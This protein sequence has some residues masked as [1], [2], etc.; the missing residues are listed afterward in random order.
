MAGYDGIT[1]AERRFLSDVRLR[2]ISDEPISAT[3]QKRAAVLSKREVRIG[4][5]ESDKP[6][7]KVE[8][9][10]KTDAKKKAG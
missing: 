1:A 10:H 2:T 7:A 9:L 3:D 8:V 4:L 5:F 6:C